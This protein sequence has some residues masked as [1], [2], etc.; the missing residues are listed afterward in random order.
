[1]LERFKRIPRAGDTVPLK[2]PP[3]GVVLTV[4]RATERAI[5]ELQV[6]GPLSPRDLG[7]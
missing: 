6:T 1:L 3:A 7:P 5:E 2:G 4:T